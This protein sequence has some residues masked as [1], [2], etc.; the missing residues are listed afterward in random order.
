QE[1]LDVVDDVDGAGTSLAQQRHGDRPAAIDV[2]DV[3]AP[4]LVVLDLGDVAQVDDLAAIDED[5]DLREVF[6]RLH[7][8][9]GRDV[10]VLFADAH[11]AGRNDLALVVDDTGDVHVRHLHRFESARMDVNLNLAKDTAKDGSGGEALQVRQFV[12]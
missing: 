9:V 7:H 8:R 10:I 1:F 4:A 5:G 3:G 12:A 2:D 11:L 6:R